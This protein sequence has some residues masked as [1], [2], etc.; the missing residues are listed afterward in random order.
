MINFQCDTDDDTNPCPPDLNEKSAV[1]F[2]E[3]AEEKATNGWD[4]LKSLAEENPVTALVNAIGGNSETLQELKTAMNITIDTKTLTESVQ[5]CNN[6]VNNSQSNIIDNT[7]C[8]RIYLEGLEGKDRI[9][10]GKELSKTLTISNITQSQKA[11]IGQEC[12]LSAMSTALTNMTAS[13]DNTALQSVLAE[14]KGFGASSKANQKT[15][16]SINQNMSACKYVKQKQCCNNQIL[17]NQ[18][19]VIKACGPSSQIN[20]SNDFR[21]VQACSTSAESSVSDSLVSSIINKTGQTAEVKSTGFPVGALIAMLVLALVFILMP[22]LAPVIVGGAAVSK[23]MKFIGPLLLILGTVLLVFYFTTQEK[24]INRQDKP[25][26]TCP[27]DKSSTTDEPKRM[28]YSELQVEINNNDSIIGYDFFIDDVNKELPESDDL[29]LAVFFT[30]VDRRS[31]C[32]N[33]DTT[34]SKCFTYIKPY[35]NN[36]LLI[37]GILIIFAGFV[38]IGYSLYKSRKGKTTKG[39]TTKGNSIFN[40][41]KP[42]KK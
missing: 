27:D 33:N 35:S 4:F 28:K 3:E 1:D 7:E 6:A 11:T 8:A 5:E 15:C 34:K 38:Q 31:M 30:G 14:A 9:E 36:L 25:F 26:S 37:F 19:N 2:C 10:A 22:V 42:K 41:F 21:A 24:E 18:L 29:G 20:Q 39:K 23:I 12:K 17:S 40:R 13:V 16:N 32:D